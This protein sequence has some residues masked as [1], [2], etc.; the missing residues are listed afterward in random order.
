MVLMVH[1]EGYTIL[2]AV[3]RGLGN[4]GF[5]LSADSECAEISLNNSASWKGV[6]V[7]KLSVC[8]RIEIV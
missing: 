2:F 8:P 6:G 5:S 3:G 4:C 1:I 7:S